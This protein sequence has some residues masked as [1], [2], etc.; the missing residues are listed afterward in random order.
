MNEK[1]KPKHTGAVALLFLT[2]AI[3]GLYMTAFAIHSMP[4][5]W[6]KPPT[7][8]I[9]WMFDT[10]AWLVALVALGKWSKEP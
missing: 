4:Y 5:S 8:V 3:I 10:L 7:V 9:A 1:E 2:V 6:Y